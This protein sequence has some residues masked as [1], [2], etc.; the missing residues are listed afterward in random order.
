MRSSARTQS[1]SGGSGGGAGRIVRANLSSRAILRSCVFAISFGSSGTWP[2]AKLQPLQRMLLTRLA[3]ASAATKFFWPCG[4][5]AEFPMEEFI[6]SENARGARLPALPFAGDHFRVSFQPG[7]RSGHSSSPSSRRR[8]DLRLLHGS[9]R[10]ASLRGRGG[11]RFIA[12]RI[13]SIFAKTRRC[14]ASHGTGRLAAEDANRL[15][16]F[17]EM[18]AL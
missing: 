17:P 12:A 5:R 8:S 2:R 9:L 13:R 4:C 15:C 7:S 14:P 16:R 6:D 3:T 11:T 18:L 10:I 1:S